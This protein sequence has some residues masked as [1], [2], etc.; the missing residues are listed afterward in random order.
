MATFLGLSSKQEKA[1]ARLEDYLNLGEIEVSLVTDS[2]TS[3]K[4]EGRQG[5]Y[6]ISYKQPHQLYRALALLSAAL[7]SGQDEVQIEEE[8][9]YEESLNALQQKYEEHKE[10]WVSQIVKRTLAM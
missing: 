10:E 2:A 8:A 4:V 5:H 3:I 6:Q 9:A 1:L 7:R